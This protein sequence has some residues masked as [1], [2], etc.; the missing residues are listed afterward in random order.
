MVI[1]AWR[2]Q[3]NT[4]WPHSSLDYLTPHE[5]KQQYHSSLNQVI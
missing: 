2:R 4:V 5:F 1:E 3:Y